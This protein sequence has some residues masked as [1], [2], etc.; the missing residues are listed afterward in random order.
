MAKIKMTKEE[1]QKF[2]FEK[3]TRMVLLDEEPLLAYQ[4]LKKFQQ[5]G[6]GEEIGFG[7]T[8]AGEG[9]YD[10]EI[11]PVDGHETVDVNGLV[12]LIDKEI[13]SINKII[14]AVSNADLAGYTAEIHKEQAVVG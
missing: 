9:N 1:V 7:M 11:V 10:Y 13:R 2:V 5:E 14:L 12:E 8:Y 6:K 4:A 3:A